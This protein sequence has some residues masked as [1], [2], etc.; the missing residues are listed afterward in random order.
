MK[1]KEMMTKDVVTAEIPGSR[2]DVLRIMVTQSKTGLP[3]IK[4]GSNKYVGFVSRQDI[5][6]NPEESQLS[7]LVDKDHPVI[8][9]ESSVK[10]AAKMLLTHDIHHLP[11]VKNDKLQGIITPADLLKLVEKKNIKKSTI[12]YVRTPCIPIYQ[13]TPLGVALATIRLAK[14]YALPVLNKKARLCGILTDRDIFNRSHIDGTIAISDLGLGEDEDS[15]SWEGLRN[16]MKF[17][18]EVS[19][20]KIPNITVKDLMVKKPKCIYS[21]RPIS[22][23]AAMMR[24]K[25]YGQLPILDSEDRLIAMIYELD[26]VAALIS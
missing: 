4:R 17:Y 16:V 9:P 6:G 11:V 20:V 23:A 25:D 13:D 8:S 3:I 2:D 1:I 12:D 14:V 22:E 7:L 24:R 15:W 26:A 19:M 10:S 21:R 5:F 18:Y